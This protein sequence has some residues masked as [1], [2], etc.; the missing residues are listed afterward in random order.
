MAEAD[1]EKGHRSDEDSSHHHHTRELAEKKAK[2]HS[3][4]RRDKER[5]RDAKVTADGVQ[6]QRSDESS[7]HDDLCGE[8]HKVKKV[9][10]VGLSGHVSYMFHRTAYS[11]H[12]GLVLNAARMPA[13]LGVG[14]LALYLL[15]GLA[16][17]M[18]V[19]G[20]GPLKTLF[21][22]VQVMTTVG[23]GETSPVTVTG[24]VLTVFYI[25]EGL[26]LLVSLLGTVFE[27]AVEKAQR[28]GE[29]TKDKLQD[30]TEATL[31]NDAVDTPRVY[32]NAV[33][34]FFKCNWLKLSPRVRAFVSSHAP[35]MICAY[36][37]TQHCAQQL[38]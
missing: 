9:V 24:K 23:W 11:P 22:S 20:W 17:Y 2:L 37:R 15:V 28:A 21:Y 32:A 16:I 35:Y 13:R 26:T 34:E 30:L 36:S 5:A 33:T 3:E 4:E 1:I 12:D 18:P 25:L 38:V 8:K 27:Y 10:A 14:A 29:T 19:E 31:G 7:E 6:P